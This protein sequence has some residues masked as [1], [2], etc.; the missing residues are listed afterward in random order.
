MASLNRVI[1]MGNLGQ[2]PELKETKTGTKVVNLSVA[3]NERYGE[4]EHTEWH[5][6]VV[7]GKTAENC[8]RFL[9]KGRQVLVE[10]KLR[11][12]KWE[13]DGTDHY[14]TE[15]LADRVTFVGGASK[16]EKSEVDF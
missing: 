10:G 16:E 11:T 13:K 5:R 6:I 15:I 9:A 7:F 4:E 1:V 14:S 8:A 3:T 2:N 12:R